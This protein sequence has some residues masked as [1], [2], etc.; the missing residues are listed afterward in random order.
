M[1]DEF[2]EAKWH[3]YSPAGRDAAR[4]GALLAFGEDVA[5]RSRLRAGR[6]HPV[7]R[8]RLPRRRPRPPPRRARFAA[9]REPSSPSGMN[10]L[11][12]IESTPTITGSMADHR[13]AVP[14]HRV[15]A[16]SQ[17][18]AQELGVRLT[19]ASAR[20]GPA[21]T[22]RS[23]SMRWSRDL[24]QNKGASLVVAGDAQPPIVHALAHAI[25]DALG[26]VGQTVVHTAPVEARPVDEMASL[27]ELVRD[28]EAGAVEM[29]LILGGNPAFTAPGGS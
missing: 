15:V 22:S 18:V 28:M 23:G 17:A 13:L 3:Q 4:A 11:Y 2:P 21:A 9:R 12:A 8:R 29:L 16:W 19:P 27:Q 24:Q 26:N 5:T 1:L 10:R 14:A 20:G 6:R 7:A 25:N